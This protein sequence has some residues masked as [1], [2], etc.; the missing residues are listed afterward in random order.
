M[1]L[2]GRFVEDRTLAEEGVGKQPCEWPEK[3][4]GDRADELHYRVLS[5]TVW[6]VLANKRGNEMLHARRRSRPI[7]GDSAVN[8]PALG[9]STFL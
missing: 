1:L 7:V 9:N 2:K 5:K 8:C 6:P 3:R 4:G